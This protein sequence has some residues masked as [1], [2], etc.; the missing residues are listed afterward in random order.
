MEKGNEKRTAE[1]VECPC[2]WKNCRRH[3]DCAACKEHHRGLN[4]KPLTACE[5]IQ[6]KK[7]ER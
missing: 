1:N 6:K 4:R 3:G 2:R 5:E 7:L